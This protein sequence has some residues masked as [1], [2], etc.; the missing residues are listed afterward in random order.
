MVEDGPS[1]RPSE[2]SWHL[3]KTPCDLFRDCAASGALNVAM[4]ETES[5]YNL[6]CCRLVP[7][8]ASPQGVSRGPV[9]SPIQTYLHRHSGKAWLS[10]ATAQP[11]SAPGPEQLARHPANGGVGNR[12]SEVHTYAGRD[13]S[14]VCRV[15]A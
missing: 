2:H 4:T 9:A 5:Q 15:L 7:S 12:V 6:L 11:I 13:Y 1:S 14:S 3:T 10:V 8:G